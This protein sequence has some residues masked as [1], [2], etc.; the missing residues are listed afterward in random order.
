MP[1]PTQRLG[2]A[3]EAL[4]ERELVRRGYR[5]VERNWRGGGGELDRIAWCGEVLCFVE[6]RARSTDAFGTPAETVG[7]EKQR[8]LIR[9]ASSYLARLGSRAVVA[10]FDVVSII[11]RERGPPEVTVI[12]GAFDASR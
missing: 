3:Q 11:L 8:R 10:R 7:R 6:V 1:S 2:A 12:P 9:A 4:A 5:I